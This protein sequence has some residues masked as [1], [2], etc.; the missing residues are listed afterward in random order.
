MLALL[1]ALIML[2][3]PNDAHLTKTFGTHQNYIQMFQTFNGNISQHQIT[4]K[5]DV[6]FGSECFLSVS[7]EWQD[8][9]GL[10][11]LKIQISKAV[12]EK[13]PCVFMFADVSV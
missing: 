10:I 13:R 12:K 3:I 11:F 9:I 7:P 1:A 5:S 6:R 8:S 2:I 4:S